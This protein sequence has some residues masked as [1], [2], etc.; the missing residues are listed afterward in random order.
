MSSNYYS[1]NA[2]RLVR[3]MQ[4]WHQQ[5]TARLEM[6]VT[7]ISVCSL[8]PGE[9][10]TGLQ[11]KREAITDAHK[12]PL[13]GFRLN[14]CWRCIFSLVFCSLYI[15]LISY[16]RRRKKFAF[17]SREME[18]YLLG[19]YHYLPHRKPFKVDPKLCV[20]STRNNMRNMAQSVTQNYEVW[21]SNKTQNFY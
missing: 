1:M 15:K 11:A 5:S 3:R 13:Y 4:Q 6:Q 12:F 8:T 10:H 16:K 7:K 9:C 17:K 19:D 20:W 21:V 14:D 2:P 18:E